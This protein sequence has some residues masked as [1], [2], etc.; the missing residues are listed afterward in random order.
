MTGVKWG[1][2]GKS[3]GVK[4]RVMTRRWPRVGARRQRGSRRTV[5]VPP[6]AAPIRTSAERVTRP[7]VKVI[8]P[9]WT[10]APT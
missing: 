2:A 9:G 6:V 3:G 1:R 7:D 5:T 10:G 4:A 8:C